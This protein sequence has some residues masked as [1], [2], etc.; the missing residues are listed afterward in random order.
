MNLSDQSL[1]GKFLNG[2][3]QAFREF[4]ERHMNLVYGVAMRNTSNASVAEE[5][6]QD[7]FV[8]VARKARELARHP[9]VAG[10]LHLTSR[11]V[12]R[13]A[14]RRL[15][16]HQRKLEHIAETTP[17]ESTSP[18]LSGHEEIDTAVSELP[19]IEREAILLRFFE[20]RDY[21]EIA[22]QLGIS[23]PAARK[24]VSRGIKRLHSGLATKLAAGTALAIPAPAHLGESIASTAFSAASTAFI[25]TKTT[26]I[27]C[28][29]IAAALITGLGL[30]GLDQAS[31]R[32]AL[33]LEL[34]N[35]R[36]QPARIVQAPVAPQKERVQELE[37]EL[38]AEKSKLA[39]AQKEI[40]ALRKTTEEIEGEVVLSYGKVEEIGSNFGSLFK[41]AEALAELEK[42]GELDD[43]ENTKRLM[44]FYMQ[45]SSMSGLSKQIIE[46][47]NNPE[48]GSRFFS[49]SYQAVLG[50]D[51]ATT[52]TLASILEEQIAKA[53]EQGVTLVNN[54]A[55]KMLE[56]GEP[57]DE[58][59]I[60]AWG[61]ERQTFYRDIRAELRNAIPPEKRADF[62]E[63]IEE[64]GI[65]FF[66]V[67]LKGQ[68][69]GFS[70][71]GKQPD[72][73]DPE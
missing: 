1:L 5:V 70:L 26:A 57:A 55:F 45:A 68:P 29:A 46:F 50:L 54:P 6:V 60:E 69:L 16:R 62:D 40:A 12:S 31:K 65:G 14:R 8:L 2:E 34:A 9:N 64:D 20:D 13:D 19:D 35:M 53:S 36:D 43:E 28:A 21:R 4:S 71:G 37:G 58:A 7:V 66:N 67:T 23:E 61:V 52:K 38:T 32:K 42:A 25:M 41:E 51:D 15:L 72:A 49:S 39:D 24:R 11:N 10:W 63:N 27:T 18:D 73:E 22:E 17:E 33:E 47:D 30:F 48:E 3:E 56:G 44:A 59:T